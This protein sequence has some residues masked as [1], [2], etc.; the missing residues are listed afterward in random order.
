MLDQVA[1]DSS[2][3]KF[4]YH[5]HGIRKIEKI[6]VLLCQCKKKKKEKKRN[7]FGKTG[8]FKKIN[9]YK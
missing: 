9:K 3:T 1:L 5:L 7:P 8:L 4:C 6:N 2:P